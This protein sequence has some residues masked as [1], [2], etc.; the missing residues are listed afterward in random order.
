MT[1]NDD[2]QR[3]RYEQIQV[4]LGRTGRN[5]SV[6]VYIYA[7]MSILALY[8]PRDPAL[9]AIPCEI[10]LATGLNGP[11]PPPRPPGR[12]PRLPPAPL[13][14]SPA[15]SGRRTAGEGRK[16]S[17]SGCRTVPPDPAPTATRPAPR[18]I[19]ARAP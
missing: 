9:C 14:I 7:S 10:C 18:T 15:S 4:D 5:T 8:S 12:L 3:C 11:S 19:P 6:Y 2:L 13:P 17:A 16:C 1:A